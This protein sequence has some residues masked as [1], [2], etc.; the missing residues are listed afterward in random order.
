MRGHGASVG[1]RPSG[2]RIFREE[3]PVNRRTLPILA[4]AA[5]SLLLAQVASAEKPCADHREERRALFGE[6]HI[7]TAISMDANVFGT[8]LRPDDAYRFAKGEAVT[9]PFGAGRPGGWPVQLERPLDFAAVTDHASN[10]GAVRLCTTEGLG[11]YDTEACQSYRQPIELQGLDN[12]RAIMDRMRKQL[13]EDLVATSV[14][15]EDGERC[16]RATATVWQETQEAA[17]RHNDT[18]EDCEFTTFVAYEYTATPELTKVHRNVIFRGEKTLPMPISYADEPDAIRLW[19]RLRDE[20]IEAGT[21]CDVLAIPHNSNLSNGHMFAVEYGDA[22]TP[23]EQARVAALRARIEPVVEMMQM[24]G[25][26]ECRNGLWN[27]FGGADELCDFEKL[28]PAATPDCE[29]G[30][31]QGALGGQGCVSR[32]D[33]A[34]YALIEGLREADRIGVNPYAFGLLAATDGH[35]G[36]P[37]A[38]EESR[39][40][41]RMGRVNPAPGMN[42]GGLAGVWAE[43]NS[44]GAI[45]DAIQRRETFGT[46][47]PRMRVR[48]FGGWDYP[49]AI[50]DASD[51]AARGYAAGVPMGGQLAERPEKVD[52]GPR[53]VVS[54]MR[55]P[56]TSAKPG[57]AL[58]RVQIIKGWADDDGGFHQS[59]I[60]IGGSPA[61]GA[62]V[63]PKSCAPAGEG[64]DTLC[65]VWTDPD[66]DP[67]KRAVYYARAVENPSCSTRDWACLAPAE[68]RPAW[69][70]GREPETIQ[71][72]AWTSPIWYTP[73]EA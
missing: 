3:V 16:R 68:R 27:V 36:T 17:H 62:S 31:G 43:E 71:E 32:L 48:F 5:V 69:C 59:V 22:K 54:A 2:S 8:R 29:Q 58:Q 46:S 42:L 9:L 11:A 37:G 1:Y 45:F 38:T 14:C 49:E 35:D 20:C 64:H 47:G 7:H 24:K 12:L 25:D 4:T 15:G 52:H 39:L 60:D 41:L 67:A 40:D 63:D 21:G 70:A 66:F 13:G 50:C 53:F 19:E 33:Y 57:T 26:S 23:V 10:F 6:L 73:P 18:S 55:D 56:G 44:R 61:N 51:L 30:T 65:R 34:R 28:R 72:R